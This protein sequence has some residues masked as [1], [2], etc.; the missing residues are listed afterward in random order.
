MCV[1]IWKIIIYVRYK[2]KCYYNTS[3]LIYFDILT[4]VSSTSFYCY[5]KM[6]ILYKVHGNLWIYK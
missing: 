4:V 2:T 5:S 6:F 1:L 3:I